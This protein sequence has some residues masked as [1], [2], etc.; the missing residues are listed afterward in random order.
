MKKVQVSA[1]IKTWI[2]GLAL[3]LTFQGLWAC[4]LRADLIWLSKQVAEEAADKN[5]E[6]RADGTVIS[7]PLSRLNPSLNVAKTLKH[8]SKGSSLKEIPPERLFL[9][10]DWKE[11]ISGLEEKALVTLPKN[12][13]ISN[14][15]L[16]PEKTGLSVDVEATVFEVRE[17]IAL[18]STCFRA[19][20]VV[21]P[22][23]I[24][25][26]DL[27]RI[28]TLMGES[29]RCLTEQSSNIYEVISI[30]DMKV[31]APGEKL[32]MIDEINRTN[33]VFS[34]PDDYSGVSKIASAVY[35][36]ALKAGLTILNRCPSSQVQSCVPHGLDVRLDESGRRDL[37]I[38]NPFKHAVLVESKRQPVSL[39]I[40]I[41]GWPEDKKQVILN[42][43]KKEIPYDTRVV[44]NALLPAEKRVLKQK[45]HC[46]Y[47]VNL[48]RAVDGKVDYV[49]TSD[50]PAVAEIW[51]EGSA[52]ICPETQK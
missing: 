36:A 17:N 29:N 48:S 27:S 43:Q 23:K 1:A 6:I 30:L 31:L 40:R 19:E 13:E 25:K 51:E 3:L 46:G 50:Y 16:I 12:A 28:N 10:L 52:R 4:S 9:D 49:S 18:G 21:I 44:N 11:L 47:V 41:F 38:E 20:T 2:T 14:G 33:V 5:L 42:I 35:E 32:S 7:I 45:G 8:M 26:S 15:V 34:E 37:V 22:P 24:T 39:S